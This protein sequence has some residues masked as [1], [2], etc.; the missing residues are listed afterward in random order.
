M[1]ERICTSRLVVL[2]L[3]LV[4][5]AASPCFAATVRSVPSIRDLRAL[6]PREDGAT[7]IVLG[8]H[9]PGDLGGGTFYWN[10]NSAASDD[11]AYTMASDR[12]S[13]GRWIRV[14]EPFVNV[15]AFGAR[16]DGVSDD[17]GPLQKA[18]DYA[19][20]YNPDLV[21]GQNTM[22]T[23]PPIP[24]S[25]GIIY[26][27]PG[28]YL[29]RVLN[30]DDKQR[31]RVL[32]TGG[33]SFHGCPGSCELIY[34]GSQSPAI[35]MRSCSSVTFSNVY[36]RACNIAGTLIAFDRSPRHP[37]D[38]VLCGFEGCVFN[39][40]S[41]T[42]IT[43]DVAYLNDSFFR[44]CAFEGGGIAITLSHGS[45]NANILQNCAFG[46]QSEVAINGLGEAWTVL[47]CAFEP[48]ADGTAS[49]YSGQ[50]CIDCRVQAL[51][52]VGNWFGD[53]SRGGAWITTGKASGLS[54]INNRFGHGP[55]PG[56]D[57]CI[58][59]N[60]EVLGLTILGNRFECATSIDL[61]SGR[62]DGGL[63]AGNYLGGDLVNASGKSRM[64]VL[65]NYDHTG[66][67]DQLGIH[68]NEFGDLERLGDLQESVAIYDS[69]RQLRGYLPIYGI[70]RD[71]QRR[72]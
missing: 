50:T 11:A 67:V 62:S 30:F 60:D 19:A 12:Q 25:G 40:T 44:D 1:F 66:F 17:T 3:F 47:G 64:T 57:A 72:R 59:Q 51:T 49:A 61:G 55:G 42:S 13:S 46:G 36:F 5:L 32:G 21:C 33:G 53:V 20:A 31:L 58:L 43:I 34:T 6:P 63:I 22:C 23:T 8:Y 9:H 70:R 71:S 68:K 38:A 7:V 37:A 26:I 45:S 27:P 54:I 35:S 24:S 41:A 48:R 16:G 28:R 56:P 15:R 39:V 69:N 4:M 18:I 65:G 52:F 29:Y 14:P 2:P 10:R